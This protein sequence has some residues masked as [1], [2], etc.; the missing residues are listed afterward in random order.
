MFH[1]QAAALAAHQRLSGLSAQQPKPVKTAKASTSRRL[2]PHL[3]RACGATD[4]A[5]FLA[6]RRNL[7]KPCKH[8]E[9]NQNRTTARRSAKASAAAIVARGR[10]AA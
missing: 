7:C 9:Q 6:D 3:C 1:D 5:L 10:R 8:R 2:Q 4:P